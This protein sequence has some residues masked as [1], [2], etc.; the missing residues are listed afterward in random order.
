MHGNLL[1]TSDKRHLEQ[2]ARLTAPGYCAGCASICESAVGPA[3]PISDIMRYLMYDRTYG[4]PE[5]AAGY[6]RK[7][8]LSLL[9]LLPIGLYQDAS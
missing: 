5:L 8:Q 6:F 1:S 2:Y 9:G 7:I 3:I 4:Q